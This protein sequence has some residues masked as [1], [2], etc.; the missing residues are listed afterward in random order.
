MSDETPDRDLY[1]PENAYEATFLE[2]P[3]PEPDLR[4][5]ALAKRPMSTTGMIAWCVIGLLA[6]ALVTL[7]AVVQFFSVNKI[8]G[9][10]KPTDLMQMQIQA[11][12]VVAQKNID[13]VLPGQP[14]STELPSQ[15]DAG[16]YEQRLCYATLVLETSTPVD[17]LNYM[18]ELEAKVNEHNLELTEN[19]TGLRD[20]LVTLFRQYD[21]GD[22]DASSLPASEQERLK[23]TLGYC[24]QLVMLPEGTPQKDQRETLVQNS[25]F[26]ILGAGL[27]VMA[28]LFAGFCGIF[29]AFV[30]LYYAVKGKMRSR[31]DASPTDHNIYIETFAV[32]LVIFFGSSFLLDLLP[33]K[34]LQVYAQPVIF[35]GSLSCLFWP[36]IRGVSFAQVRRDIGWSSSEPLT[37]I[38]VS[39]VTYL[40]TLPCLIPG[41]VI[42][43]I[44][45]L[46]IS[47]V[48]TPHE[49]APQASP[50]HPIQELLGSGQWGLI[51]AVV[52]TACIGAPVVEETMFRG[53][54]YRHLRDWSRH[55]RVWVSILFS[56]L[57]NG[58]IFAA[59]HPQ[60]LLAIPVL[61]TL[62]LCFSLTREWR[63]SLLSPMIMHGVHN[64]AITCI[65]LMI[66]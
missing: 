47:L 12:S 18:D 38:F 10:A 59:I 33:T 1:E 60:G 61:M 7:V 28:G 57:F 16:C 55:W 32:W 5:S 27:V 37:D 2:S 36:V 54:L 64:F 30:F 34:D 35:F 6:T 31:V 53:V 11:K 44:A 46:L 62:A 26:K 42:V 66:L 17:A 52:I 19:Q 58:F 48:Q 22:M 51:F 15:L 20:S 63:G 41:L 24:G 25:V 3:K 43:L 50:G 9:D 56:A 4:G 13:Q 8:G 39:P 49:F 29:I 40:A 23:E 21:S 65:T 14:S 45:G